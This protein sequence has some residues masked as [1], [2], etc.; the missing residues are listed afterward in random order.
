MSKNDKNKKIKKHNN[1]TINT[2]SALQGV[3][4]ISRTGLGF[5]AVEGLT[6]DIVIRPGSFNTALHGD[7]VS[8]AIENQAHRS[9][10]SRTY[11]KILKVL[12]RKQTKFIGTIH[13]D[14]FN[15]M[16]IADTDKQ[17]P[18]IFVAQEDLLQAKDGQRV[19]CKIPIG[20]KI[21]ANQMAKLLKYLPTL[22]IAM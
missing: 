16:F 15:G 2:S 13:I 14:K 1:T 17:M 9:Q 7:S 6:V 5:V 8:V 4:D 21:N 11:G 18:N 10:S 19:V 12:L 3:L 22:A 20:A